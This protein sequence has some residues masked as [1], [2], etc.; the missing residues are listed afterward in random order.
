MKTATEI[1]EAYLH[2]LASQAGPISLF[3]CHETGLPEFTPPERWHLNVGECALQF[4]R[5]NYNRFTRSNNETYNELGRTNIECYR[6]ITVHRI[7]G[8]NG[9]LIRK[10]IDFA[11]TPEL[12]ARYS[13][14]LHRLMQDFMAQYVQESQEVAT[15]LLS[16]A[17]AARLQRFRSIL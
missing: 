13:E 8:K 14:L 1:L 12:A 10:D 15:R 2:K 9:N 4:E 16:E 6:H 11:M 17:E 5:M 7:F 3:V